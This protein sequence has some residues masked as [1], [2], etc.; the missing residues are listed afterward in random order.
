MTY[1]RLALCGAM[2]AVLAT[3]ETG[4]P[5]ALAQEQAAAAQASTTATQRP[6]PLT[7][8]ELEVLVARIALYPDELVALVC[9]ASLFPLQIVE[10]QRY[11]EK[12]EKDKRLQ[13]KENGTA[14]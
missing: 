8:D 10:A 1:A 6:E 14:A 12:Q 9:A 5:P 13:P 7:D 11:L 4:A 2:L 3:T